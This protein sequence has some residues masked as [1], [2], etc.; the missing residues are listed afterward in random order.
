MVGRDRASNMLSGTLVGPGPNNSR[1]MLVFNVVPVVDV[2]A[3]LT[4]LS[5]KVRILWP[6]A[7][8]TAIVMSGRSSSRELLSVTTRSEPQP[9]HSR[10]FREQRGVENDFHIF[11][12]SVQE[13]FR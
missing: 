6:V 5:G 4:P 12:S 11:L 7:Q 2:F 9:A 8:K 13:I 1:R 10:C 3:M